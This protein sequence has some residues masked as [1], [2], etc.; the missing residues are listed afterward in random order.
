MILWDAVNDGSESCSNPL[1]HAV[2]H[3]YMDKVKS[4]LPGADFTWSRHFLDVVDKGDGPT[5]FFLN[6]VEPRRSGD[7]EHKF[8]IVHRW[9]K[10][11]TEDEWDS[12]MMKPDLDNASHAVLREFIVTSPEGRALRPLYVA[13]LYGS[14]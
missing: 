12:A 9:D 11:D 1:N 10:A 7:S 13:S 8:Y 6:A 4:A 2:S 3:K 14:G 5:S